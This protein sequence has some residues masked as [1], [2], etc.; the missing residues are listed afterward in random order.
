MA[1][2]KFDSGFIKETEIKV[3][4][5]LE[6]RM[7]SVTPFHYVSY[8]ISKFFNHSPP[9]RNLR[10]RVSELIMATIKDI[11]LMTHRPS[12][13]AGAATLVVLDQNL[14]REAV[15][16]KINALS[17]NGFPQIE[18][19]LFCYNKL[20]ELEREKVQ[21]PSSGTRTPAGLSPSQFGGRPSV[22]PSTKRKRGLDFRDL[23]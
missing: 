13:I 21:L 3:L 5:A 11:Y 4:L 15:E 14:S 19:V 9:Q 8:F 22:N 12:A 18:D 7:D 23:E 10:G 6:W 1:G 17:L 20:Q 16:S 2:Y